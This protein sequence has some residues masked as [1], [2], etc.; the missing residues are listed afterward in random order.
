MPGSRTPSPPWNA[1]RRVWQDAASVGHHASGAMPADRA[2]C[3]RR[4]SRDDVFGLHEQRKPPFTCEGGKGR[5]SGTP[6]ASPGIARRPISG[7][8]SSAQ[9]ATNA[10]EARSA[11]VASSER[12]PAGLTKV[13]SCRLIG[14]SSALQGE[15][16]NALRDIVQL[17]IGR[18]A[19][20]PAHRAGPA[21]PACSRAAPPTGRP[22]GRL[23]PRSCGPLPSGQGSPGWGQIPAWT[24]PFPSRT[25]IDSFVTLAMEGR[26]ITAGSAPGNPTSTRVAK[27]VA[28]NAPAAEWP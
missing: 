23:R 22:A 27:A 9:S 16:M 12:H 20:C 28:R 10:S 17:S 6:C 18:R 13:R 14:R 2:Q 19:A 26:S 24:W 1:A 25:S 3:G 5:P 15:A 7:Q 4:R 11:R 21:H 8:P